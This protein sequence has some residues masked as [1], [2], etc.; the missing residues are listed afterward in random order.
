MA[1]RKLPKELTTRFR[2]SVQSTPS[3]YQSRLHG[4]KA[5]FLAAGLPLIP[6]LSDDLRALMVEFDLLNKIEPQPYRSK[7]KRPM[8]Q[9]KRINAFFAYRSFYTTSVVN[10]KHQTELSK[11][12]GVTWKTENRKDVWRL[13]ATLYNEAVARREVIVNFVQW[14]CDSLTLSDSASGTLT[15]IDPAEPVT[16][17]STENW[18][19]LSAERPKSVEN[20][21]L[22]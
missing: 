9:L 17:I 8:K 12:L 19:F 1:K 21:F 10:P 7:P 11:K 6:E 13:Y 16:T 14:L 22:L 15:A 2:S 18:T 5:F 20:I 3:K 4:E